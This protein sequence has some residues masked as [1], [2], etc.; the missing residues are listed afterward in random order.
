[1]ISEPF[2]AIETRI[3]EENGFEDWAVEYVYADPDFSDKAVQHQQS[4]EAYKV[5]VITLDRYYKETRRDPPTD[6]ERQQLQEREE[7]LAARSAFMAPQA[8][9]S[10]PDQDSDRD[11]VQVLLEGKS[12]TAVEELKSYGYLEGD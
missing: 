1:M 7:K 6:E 11:P 12:A 9:A 3:L 4:L 2:E 10:Q 5:G 8:N